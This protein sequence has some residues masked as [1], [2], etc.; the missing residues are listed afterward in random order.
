M[1]RQAHLPRA[2]PAADLE[3]LVDTERR[4]EHLLAEARAEAAT[5]R[6]VAQAEV[7]DAERARAG[8]LLAAC[9]AVDDRIAAATAARIAALEAEG[10]TGR[11]RHDALVGDALADEARRLAVRLAAL[12][13]G[14]G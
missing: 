3:A 5:R 6:E 7:E 2:A 10:A 8:L 13:E 12:I 11:R 9:R 4:L 14:A 1:A